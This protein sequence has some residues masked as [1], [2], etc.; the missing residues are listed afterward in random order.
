MQKGIENIKKTL[1]KVP[2]NS[3]VYKM[4]SKNKEILYI[5]KAKNLSKR[6]SS[7]T[8]IKKFNNRLQRM[9]S[10]IDKIEFIITEDESRALLLEAALIKEIKPKFNILL[11]DDKTYPNIEL[12]LGHKWPQIKKHRGKKNS[13]HIYYGP[14][15]SAYHV[16]TTI[17]TLQKIFS[18][19]SCSD[20]ELANRK[21]PCIQ[22][23]IHRCSAPCTGE[24]GKE[25]YELIVDNLLNYMNG[26]SN[27]LLNRL[28]NEMNEA[29]QVLDYEKAA[30]I[31]DKIRS[32]KKTNQLFHNKYK[33]LGEADIFCIAKLNNQIAIEVIFC[34]NGQNYG[35]NTH[36]LL[37]KIED[38]LT[39]ILEKFL[40]QF[41][42]NQTIP[43]N[44]IVSHNLLQ[45]NLLEKAF[46]FKTKSKIKI[47]NPDESSVREVLTNGKKKAEQSLAKYLA[48][49]EKNIN[50]L[51]FLRNK[52]DFSKDINKIEVY[53]N[54]HFAGKEAVGSY[55]V[56]SSK[57]FLKDKYRK[58]NIKYSNT[59]DDYSMMEEVLTR[60]IKYK[61]F[62]DLIII[63]GGKGQLS[64]ANGVFNLKE[65]KN[66]NIISIS[67]G[68]ERNSE[69]EKFFNK[70]GK[71]ISI[72]KTDPLFYYLLRL[73]DEAHRYAISNH[74]ILRKKNLFT[75]EIDLI[76]NVGSKKKKNL[77]LF[78]NSLDEIKTANLNKLKSV[79]GINSKTANNIFNFFNNQ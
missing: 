67:K 56:A 49:Q 11:K 14:F 29:S 76:P 19:R 44:I 39:E 38:S 35:S 5:G 10:L 21:R 79:P 42:N 75:S 36:F 70:S 20:H 23:Q 12:R 2:S 48:E 34:R 22:F 58:F 40:V 16:N 6:I 54:S 77:L 7:Y 37:V 51:K 4:L 73:R 46:Y 27:N 17:D 66:I 53:D 13:K 69:K 30:N 3:G 78:F 60:R 63:D 15:A 72:E 52:F 33:S 71:E 26:K 68:K 45:K 47:F 8:N 28:I 57:G 50:L 9:V 41:Y 61:D 64:K 25:S 31:R 59:Q 18:L 55:I 1:G 65:L 74:K 62:P 32:L 43:N 24:I